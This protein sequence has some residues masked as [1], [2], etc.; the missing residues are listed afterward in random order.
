MG[1]INVAATVR[2]FGDEE[3]AL[4]GDVPTGQVR[5]A[6]IGAMLVDTGALYLGLPADIVAALGLRLLREVP[7]ITANGPARMRYFTGVTLEVMGRSD[8]FSCIELPTGT[9]QLLGA[10]PMEVLGLEP[11]LRNRRLIL[12][13]DE[14]PQNYQIMM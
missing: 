3:R 2:N 1:Q 14:G 10:V 7:V 5:F 11:D 4:A 12:L 6:V 9:I 8:T 13:P